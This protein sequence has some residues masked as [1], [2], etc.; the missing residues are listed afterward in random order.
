MSGNCTWCLATE[1]L[2]MTVMVAEMIAV[3]MRVRGESEW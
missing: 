1:K 2:E 3:A